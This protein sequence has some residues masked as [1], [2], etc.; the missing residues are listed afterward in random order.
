MLNALRDQLDGTFWWSVRFKFVPKT[1][2]VRMRTMKEAA[3]KNVTGTLNSCKKELAEVI[4]SR[5]S[6]LL[7]A[8]KEFMGSGTLSLPTR[9]KLS[10]WGRSSMTTSP[11]LLPAMLSMLAL[12]AGAIMLSDTSCVIL[13]DC[14]ATASF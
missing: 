6:R 1:G 14:K 11:P 10:C 13:A 4:G 9:P 8:C 5:R 2:R 7:Y 3:R 12:C